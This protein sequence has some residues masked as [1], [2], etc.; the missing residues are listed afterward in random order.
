MYKLSGWADFGDGL[1]VTDEDVY[2]YVKK[3]SRLID[4]LNHRKMV[5]MTFWAFDILSKSVEEP[6]DGNWKF[7]DKQDKIITKYKQ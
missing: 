7:Y 6:V 2:Q 1:I 4:R 5:E 3:H